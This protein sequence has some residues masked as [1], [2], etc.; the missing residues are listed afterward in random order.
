MYKLFRALSVDALLRFFNLCLD[1]RSAPRMCMFTILIGILKPGKD[2]T[3]PA[4]Y[5][6]VGLE[7]C[8]LKTFTLL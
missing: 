3:D 4:S 1:L 7:F 5:R 2:A 6:L 8:L